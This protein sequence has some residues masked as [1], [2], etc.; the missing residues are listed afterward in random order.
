M[1]SQII[2]KGKHEYRAITV[3]GGASLTIVLPKQYATGLGL[4]R[5][6]WVKVSWEG[7]RIILEKA[8]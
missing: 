1:S 2:S 3:V 8:E 4:E 5:G 6:D 7:K